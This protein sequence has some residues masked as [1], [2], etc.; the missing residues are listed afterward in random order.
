M[1]ALPYHIIALNRRVS[2]IIPTR[3]QI[4]AFI[5]FLRPFPNPQAPSPTSANVR[6]HQIVQLAYFRHDHRGIILDRKLGELE[7]GELL[8]MWSKSKKTPLKG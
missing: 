7:G 5:S 4:G 8:P 1:E 3:E 6:L 2:M